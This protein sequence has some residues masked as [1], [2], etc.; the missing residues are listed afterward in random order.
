MT[1]WMVRIALLVALAFG[2]VLAPSAITQR[3]DAGTTA[4]CLSSQE[5]AFL[6]KINAYR[7]SKG[8]TPLMAT[9]SLDVS[10]Y[11]H[12]Y[13]MGIKRYFSHTGSDGS[14]PWTRMA[15]EGYTYNTTKG[16]NIAA[17]YAT[18]DTVFTAWKNSAGH[19]ANMLNPKFKA[20]G[21]GMVSVSGSPYGT[22]WTTDFGGV[23]DARPSCS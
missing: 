14:S 1:R 4:E 19:N 23:I 15:R 9:R 18:A 13:D 3:A 20:I 10:S 2:A 11:K 22:Y 7:Q 6:S 8:L 21:I 5:S 16:E 17:G 12:S